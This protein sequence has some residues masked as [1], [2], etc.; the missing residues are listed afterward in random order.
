MTNQMGNLKHEEITKN[1]SKLRN[2]LNK[3]SSTNK[4]Q[5][6]ELMNHKLSESYNVSLKIIVDVSKLLQQYMSYFNEIDQIVSSIDLSNTNS[7]HFTNIN[8]LTSEK[9]DELTVNFQEQLNVLTPIY[10]KNNMSTEDLTTYNKLLNNV[11]LE[12][13]KIAAV[14][15]G[16][17]KLKRKSSKN[18]KTSFNFNWW[19]YWFYIWRGRYWWWHFFKSYIIAC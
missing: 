4:L 10:E 6:T 18:S 5:K 12:S 13:K 17:K 1:I 7:N 19:V 14:Q 3:S 8:K 9:I 15:Q 16:G 11:N 2:A